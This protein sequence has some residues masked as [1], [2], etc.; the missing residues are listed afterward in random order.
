MQVK[1]K[2]DF[3]KLDDKINQQALLQGNNKITFLSIMWFWVQ[4][5][6]YYRKVSKDKKYIE[7]TNYRINSLEKHC[8]IKR[9]DFLFTE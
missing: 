6:S 2:M 7:L 4:G 8:F 3:Q 5:E 1:L 9:R